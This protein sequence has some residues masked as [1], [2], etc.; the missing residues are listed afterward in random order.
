MKR[1]LSIAI[2]LSMM[3]CAHAQSI[4]FGYYTGYQKLKNWGTGKA[5][6]YSA[7][8]LVNQPSMVGGKV[9]KIRIPMEPEAE[10]ITACSAF[11]T[12]EL[13]ASSG[14][15]TGDIANVEFTPD[16]EEWI[17]VTL[18]EPYTITS[19]PFYVGYT[20]KVTSTNTQD[21][22]ASPMVF[23]MDS[24]PD[25]LMVVTSRTYR[26]WTDLGSAIGG[27]LAAQIVVE[28]DMLKEN[29]AAVGKMKNAY[30]P[31]NGESTMAVT[32]LNHGVSDINSIDYTYE[33]AGQQTQGH[34]DVHIAHDIYGASAYIQVTTPAISTLGDHQ[35]TFTITHVNGK[36]NSETLAASATNTLRVVRVVP[37]KHPLMEEF[38]G[39]W[40]G[41]CPSGWAS[42]RWMNE[43]HP[44]FICASYHNQDAMQ[45]TTQYPVKVDGFPMAC[46]DRNHMTDAYQGDYKRDLG[47]ELSWYDECMEIPSANVDVT[48]SL[49]METGV[50]TVDAQFTFCKDVPEAN[51][52]IAYLITADGLCGTNRNW[53]Q[54]NYFSAEYSNGDYNNMYIEAMDTI[55][56]GREYMMLTYDDVVVA[57]SG[58]AGKTIDDVIPSSCTDGQVFTHSV[59]FLTTDMT[60][61]YVEGENLVQHPDRMH[62]IALIYNKATGHVENC[63]KCPVMMI[64]EVGGDGIE[65]VMPSLPAGHAAYNLAGQRVSSDFRG[66]VIKGGKKLYV[67]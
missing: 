53:R 62:A 56:Q 49:D 6:T 47:I 51:Y 38:T 35:G 9:T 55:N 15:A 22:N 27:V 8:M 12:H 54:H 61:T 46:F 59:T 42:M 67:K 24:Q 29:S 58:S 57:Q 45:I 19:E 52:G 41:F 23:G 10:N 39:A 2:T 28:G 33:A 20:F 40:C 66:I 3:L 48:S 4:T 25:G 43:H 60:S 30:V 63:N 34:A 37:V 26:K 7:A 44:D 31:L 5:E 18:P 14:K 16:G 64:T 32:I 1:I 65:S 50:L 17:T 11:L 21:M 13:K 36:P